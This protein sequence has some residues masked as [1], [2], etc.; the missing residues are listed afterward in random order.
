MMGA[1]GV[2]VGSLGD[3]PPPIS[4]GQGHPMGPPQ[5][6]DTGLGPK[7]IDIEGCIPE[8]STSSKM[9]FLKNS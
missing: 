1:G 3:G 9:D 7:V 5:S 2:V 4:Q 8:F 6:K